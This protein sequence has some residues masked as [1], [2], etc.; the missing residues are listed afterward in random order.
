MTVS[1][2]VP[3]GSQLSG[4]KKTRKRLP[5]SSVNGSE[6]GSYRTRTKIKKMMV[7][8]PWN[9]QDS[10]HCKLLGPGPLSTT[11]QDQGRNTYWG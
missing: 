2:M 10:R 6:R 3:P 9:S 11:T 1:V 7:A 5:V 4:E 8:I